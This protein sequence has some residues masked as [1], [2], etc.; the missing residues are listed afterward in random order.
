MKKEL[1]TKIICTIGPTSK[2]PDVLRNLIAHGASALRINLSHTP[3]SEATLIAQNIRRISKTIPLILDTQGKETRFYSTG[4]EINL[5]KGE[6]FELVKPLAITRPE[7][8]LSL[9][10]NDSIYINDNGIHLKFLG[11]DKKTGV[12]RFKVL[13]AGTI[14]VPKNIRFAKKVNIDR[15][16]TDEDH[17]A[18]HIGKKLGVTEVSLSYVE[19]A[20]DVAEARQAVGPKTKLSSKIETETAVKNLDELIRASDSIMIDRNDLGTEIGY[21][22][23]PLIQKF[24]TQ[25]CLAAKRPIFVATHLLETMIPGK[26]KPTRGEVNDIVNLVLDGVNGLILSSETAV[27][28]NPV[29][30]LDTMK[31]LV[32]EA[33]LVSRKDK[34]GRDLGGIVKQLEKLHYI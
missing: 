13:T 28:E 7:V 27:G 26:A 2:S 16:L 21:E 5:S 4:K 22:R 18:I 32:T 25:K 10:P 1:R 9:K 19:N 12:V 23:I 30:I 31:K 15:L 33:E 34:W 20:K 6:Q 14:G 3:L 11:R 29:H 24:I 17:A 8:L